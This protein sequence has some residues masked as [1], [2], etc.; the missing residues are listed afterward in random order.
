MSDTLNISVFRFSVVEIE[1]ACCQTARTRSCIATVEHQV[2]VLPIRRRV[3]DPHKRRTSRSM[4]MVPFCIAAQTRN[5]GRCISGR[6]FLE[7]LF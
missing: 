2:V 7:S 1:A 4:G 5:L 3:R 6:R